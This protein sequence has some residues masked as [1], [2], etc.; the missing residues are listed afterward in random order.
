[1]HASNAGERLF[2]F[3]YLSSRRTRIA[4]G[5]FFITE[6]RTSQTSH[7]SWTGREREVLAGREA[8]RMFFCFSRLDALKEWKGRRDNQV[9]GQ[10]LRID[11][12]FEDVPW[13]SS[14]LDWV[15]GLGALGFD[16][17]WFQRLYLAFFV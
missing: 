12:G 3:F 13:N 16:S 10:H 15:W 5:E 4:R 17:C 9:Q 2:F 1:M 14:L 11:G 8:G 7:M 6:G